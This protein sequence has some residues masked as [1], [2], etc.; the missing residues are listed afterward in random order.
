[1]SHKVDTVYSN[2]VHYY[3]STHCRH[4]DH[5]A[6]K[7]TELAPGV[8]RK[9]AQCKKCHTPCRC[10]CHQENEHTL[11]VKALA[12]LSQ[13]E[14]GDNDIQWDEDRYAWLGAYKRWTEKYQGETQ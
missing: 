11:L 3:W 14:D 1:M 10:T 9:P 5:E 7:A 4:D 2:G 8:P 13:A 6:C 12:L